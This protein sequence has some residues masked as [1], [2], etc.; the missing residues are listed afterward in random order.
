[1]S[2]LSYD[3]KVSLTREWAAKDDSVTN[4]CLATRA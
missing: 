3:A 4:Y 2:F 1:M